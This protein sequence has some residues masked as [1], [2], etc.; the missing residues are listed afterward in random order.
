MSFASLL[1]SVGVIKSD[2]LNMNKKISASSGEI[3]SISS[4]FRSVD[5]LLLDKW[6]SSRLILF[7]PVKKLDKLLVSNEDRSLDLTIRNI[8]RLKNNKTKET[9][10]IPKNENII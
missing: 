8:A 7:E 6:A 2:N 3:S 10:T 5:H 4:L 1:A 9:L